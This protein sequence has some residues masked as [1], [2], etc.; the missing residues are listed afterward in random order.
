MTNFEKQIRK[1]F[2]AIKNRANGNLGAVRVD[3]NARFK[4]V[5]MAIEYIMS[6]DDAGKIVVFD[7]DGDVL[8]IFYVEPANYDCDIFDIVYDYT[9]ND[10][11]AD[12]MEMLK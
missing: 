2:V 4:D 9:D 10:F 1:L 8:G 12:V 5:S 11:C 6:I 3:N 7:K